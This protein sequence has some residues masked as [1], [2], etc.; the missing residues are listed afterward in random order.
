[1]KIKC[2]YAANREYA[3][4]KNELVNRT[5]NYVFNSKF[6]AAQPIKINITAALLC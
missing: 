3:W 6:H 5:R 4:G 1:M 2:S